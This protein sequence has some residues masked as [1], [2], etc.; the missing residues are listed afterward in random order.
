LA[1]ALHLQIATETNTLHHEKEGG[2]QRR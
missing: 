2:V 1:Q